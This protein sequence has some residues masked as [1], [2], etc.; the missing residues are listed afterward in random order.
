VLRACDRP[1]IH[2][3]SDEGK[4]LMVRIRL[5]RRSEQPTA[6]RSPTGSSEQT[7]D[8]FISY[9]HA[10]DGKLAPALQSALHGFARPWNR[11]RALRVFR[12]EAS[13]SAN[14]ALW[15]SIE[16]ALHGSAFFILLASPEAARS[17]WVDRE[18]G[19]WLGHK[20]RT[21]LLI[22]LTDGEAV[23]DEATG[24]FDWDRTTAVPRS[25][26]GVFEEE[27]RHID[28]RWARLSEDVSLHNPR[29]RD[30]VADLAAPLHG[31]AKDELVGEDVR[32]HRR[33]VRL[34]R[35]AITVVVTFALVA[36]S[37]TVLTLRQLD[38]TRRARNEA[39]LRARVAT[40][41]LLARVARDDLNDRPALALLEGLKGFQTADT[42]DSR[43]ALA[44]ALQRVP[45]LATVLPADGQA[46]A[47]AVS[48]VG[49][50]LALGTSDG[51]IALWAPIKR[52]PIGRL[53]A[54][55]GQVQSLAFSSDG[56]TLAADMAN[57]PVLLWDVRSRRQVQTIAVGV[58]D[59]TVAFSLK[60]RG[61]LIATDGG[62][63]A[64]WRPGQKRAV[65][66]VKT[67]FEG[68]HD[69]AYS[70]DGRLVAV[71]ADET[72]LVDPS[73]GLA[74]SLNRQKRMANV[75]CV[76]F[77]PDGKLLAVGDFEG[78]ITLWDVHR[79]KELG[80][81]AGHTRGVTSV[82]FSPN[83]RLLAAGGEDGTTRVWDVARKTMVGGP[84]A[85]PGRENPEN[86]VSSVTFVTD[87]FV[88]AATYDGMGLLWHVR[89]KPFLNVAVKAPSRIVRSIAVSPDKKTFATG[90]DEGGISVLWNTQ[91][92]I[93][94]ATLS[95]RRSTRRFNSRTFVAG[96]VSFSPDGGALLAG[97]NGDAES[98]ALLW[99]LADRRLRGELDNSKG[100]T[101]AIFISNGRRIL[102]IRDESFVV[103]DSQSLKVAKTIK[104]PCFP[105][106]LALNPK[107]GIVAVGCDGPVILFDL[108]KNREVST[109]PGHAG[110]V[111]SLAFS[112]DGRILA[113]AGDDTSVML[114]DV[115]RNRRIATLSGH[116]KVVFSLV[117]SPDGKQL[118]SASGDGNVVIWDAANKEL[119]GRLRAGGSVLSVQYLNPETLISGSSDATVRFWNLSVKAW[120]QRACEIVGPL[121]TSERF[122]SLLQA[123]A[124]NCK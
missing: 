85:L 42:S 2:D 66:T 13:L 68:L 19:Y 81:L 97:G 56:S 78:A 44:E 70:P 36:A 25:L 41:R 53:P 57:G 4:P 18:I 3:V 84:L 111:G 122:T 102:A 39:E 51:S 86:P 35:A 76:A 74:V 16:R 121:T 116:S 48:P 22:A 15:S 17:R 98:R 20:P 89:E 11:L 30:A 6:P 87:D 108:D 46:T 43:N 91:R 60:E 27:P 10:V 96:S 109:L 63:L 69:A 73:S 82:A 88:V 40:S 37:S 47:V 123:G 114:W 80:L 52:L 64:L 58:W 7:Y 101:N 33:T 23:W 59:A 34:T 8:A 12:D 112:P 100:V 5:P 115:G 75:S 54:S 31:R 38:Q 26:K 92:R 120:E 28:L 117:F 107:T 62:V 94:T 9:S 67:P 79:R 124:P 24:D 106:A 14:P 118:A 72:A 61:V 119:L 45:R 50:V 29:F 32:Q 21:N 113:S 49:S 65:W 93:P 110:A 104:A 55:G 83:G 105:A 1:G 103:W 95:Y 90:S 99:S 71:A 77:S